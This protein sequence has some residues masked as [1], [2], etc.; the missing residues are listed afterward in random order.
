MEDKFSKVIWIFDKVLMKQ[1]RLVK[2]ENLAGNHFRNHSFNFLKIEYEYAENGYKF[3]NLTNWGKGTCTFVSSVFKEV[4]SVSFLPNKSAQ[5]SC[6]EC[7][8]LI[9]EI[10]SHFL[11]SILRPNPFNFYQVVIKRLYFKL[12]LDFSTIHWLK[13]VLHLTRGKI[14]ML[15]NLTL[16]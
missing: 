10:V 5:S 14:L 7:F 2:K 3:K 13:L 1:S 11:Y 4:F 8:C 9:T 6:F 16:A 12:V 15:P